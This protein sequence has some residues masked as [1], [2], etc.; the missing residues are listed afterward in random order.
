[1][2]LRRKKHSF[3]LFF[4][5][6]CCIVF[7]FIHFLIRTRFSICVLDFSNTLHS[8]RIFRVS[9]LSSFLASLPQC[10]CHEPNIG[11][12]QI[13]SAA[14]PTS[15]VYIC[16]CPFRCSPVCLLACLV[17]SW[18]FVRCIHFAFSHIRARFA[19]LISYAHF[20]AFFLGRLSHTPFIWLIVMLFHSVCGC[21]FL[22]DAAHLSVLQRHHSRTLCTHM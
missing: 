6:R 4:I 22:S 21:C 1:M 3:S 2:E 17:A 10:V 14:L 9:R 18:N 16:V 11:F 13:L 12:R 19:L 7:S 20:P 5:C 8:P 15:V